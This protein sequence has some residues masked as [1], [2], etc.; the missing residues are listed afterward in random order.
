MAYGGEKATILS[1]PFPPYIAAGDDGK[2][3]GPAV[4]VVRE[5]FEHVGLD[6]KIELQPWSRA[7]AMAEAVPE[8][9]IFS[10]AR[11]PDREDSF[12]WIGTVAPYKVR[13]FKLRGGR[14]PATDEWQSLHEYRVAGQLKDVKALFLQTHGFNVYFVPAAENTIKMLY[15]SRVDL[16]AGDAL[17]LPYRVR[18]L[19]LEINDL[20]V[21][22]EIPE[23]SS[24]LYLAANIKT[25]RALLR[26]VRSGLK[27]LKDSGRFD[28]IWRGVATGS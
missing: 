3:A 12:H 23:L 16:I 27:A 5:A 1:T 21:A 14:V 10:I 17:S 19:G 24:D 15:A 4:D 2:P 18:E 20:A 13:L 7:Y 9:F 25:D 26:Q 8:T 28:D 11:R 22:A 6:C